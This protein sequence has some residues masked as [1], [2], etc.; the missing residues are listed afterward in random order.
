MYVAI[1]SGVRGA[2]TPAESLDE[3]NTNLEEVFAL[4]V[5]EGWLTAESAPRFSEIPADDS[6]LS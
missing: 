1:V 6:P 5:E 3:L 2:H 4:C